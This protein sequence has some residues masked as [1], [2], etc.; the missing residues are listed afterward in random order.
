MYW[1]C[2]TD[3]K[4][5]SVTLRISV[6]PN[7]NVVFFH[8]KYIGNTHAPNRRMNT[9]DALNRFSHSTSR[10]LTK[11]NAANTAMTRMYFAISDM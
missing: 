6:S 10:R 3:L 11:K 8:Q 5:V 7:V 2:F 9:T 4:T 1:M